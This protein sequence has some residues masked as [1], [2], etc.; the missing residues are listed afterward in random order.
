MVIVSS[1]V[2]S[3]RMLLFMDHK[4]VDLLAL[5]ATLP[6]RM[7]ES[8]IHSRRHMLFLRPCN[9]ISVHCYAN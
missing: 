8:M 1:N 5:T 9:T 2:C 3:F 6:D 4:D 7:S